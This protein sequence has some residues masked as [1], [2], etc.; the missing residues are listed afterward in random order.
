MLGQLAAIGHHTGVA[1]ILGMKFSGFFAWWLW[2]GIYL[3][4][5][6]GFQKK[7]RVSIDWALDSIFSRELVQLPT[8]RAPTV[9]GHAEEGQEQLRKAA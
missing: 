1:Q 2:R 9:P 8:L 7:V 6:P 5:L 4:K 3:G